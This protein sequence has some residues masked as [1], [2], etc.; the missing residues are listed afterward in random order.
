MLGAEHGYMLLLL[1]LKGVAAKQLP[2]MA[3]SRLQAPVSLGI[4]RQ[5]YWVAD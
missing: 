5:E 3:D 1:W 4:L 2:V